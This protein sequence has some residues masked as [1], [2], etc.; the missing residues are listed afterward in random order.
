V[1]AVALPLAVAAPVFAS[2]PTVTV[3]VTDWST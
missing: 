3:L 1:R 2:E